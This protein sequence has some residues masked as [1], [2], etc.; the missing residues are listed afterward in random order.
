MVTVAVA[1]FG[2]TAR[3]NDNL[4]V[5]QRLVAEAAQRGAKLVV[6][7]EESM[8]A[9]RHVEGSLADAVSGAWPVFVDELSSL[10]EKHGV[11]VVAGGF[12]PSETDK[13]FNTL[14]AVNDQG[15]QVATYR[16]L[17]LYDAFK[18]RESD[19]ISAGDRGLVTLELEGITWG[20]QTCYDIRFPEVAR[21]LTLRGAQALI[22]PAAWFSGDHK[23][24]HWQSL[25]SVRA[26]ENTVWVVAAD[27]V[28]PDT[29]G[30][31]TIVDPLGLPVAE[32][33][34]EPEGVAMAEITTDRV[35]EVRAT[36][37]VLANRRTDVSDLD[38]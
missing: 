20:L 26:V 30:H 28:G 11:H 14:L 25:V 22:T 35:D 19:D 34:T 6:L 24:A 18:N 5:I 17:H 9:Y 36:V 2:P 13:P 3:V 32:L 7:P 4:A 23:K 33:A 16:K 38:N 29:I 21:A 37:P 8:L 31:S 15:E 10:A 12:E 27:T 1:Q